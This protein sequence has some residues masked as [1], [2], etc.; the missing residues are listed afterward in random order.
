MTKDEKIDSIMELAKKM[1]DAD[2]YAGHCAG[3][4]DAVGALV[5]EGDASALE[6]AIE[7]KLREL[8][9]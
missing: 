7:S 9:Q 3:R 1:S 8:I 5:R 6:I 4:N 2:F